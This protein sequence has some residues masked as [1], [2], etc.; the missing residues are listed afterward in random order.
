MKLKVICLGIFFVFSVFLISR[1]FSDIDA[2]SR[3]LNA[4]M[5]FI[6]CQTDFATSIGNSFLT[7]IPNGTYTNAISTNITQLQADRTQLQSFADAKNVTSFRDY[8]FNYSS[9]L[10][11]F[12]ASLLRD[13]IGQ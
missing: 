7:N 13:A 2:G 11:E 6:S 9:D 10:K 4:S 8:V 1:S 3:V 12:V 5:Q